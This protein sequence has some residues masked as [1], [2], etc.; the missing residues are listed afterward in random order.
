MSATAIKERASARRGKLKDECP[1]RRSA[2]P[3]AARRWS[4]GRDVPFWDRP[5][6]NGA[7]PADAATDRSRRGAGLPSVGA[8]PGRELAG[9]G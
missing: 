4:V 2:R 3:D 7:D 9:M 6:Q 5:G 8:V 1:P